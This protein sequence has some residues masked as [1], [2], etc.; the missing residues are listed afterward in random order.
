MSTRKFVAII[1]LGKPWC[2]LAYCIMTA[3]L[4]WGLGNSGF[5]Y[6]LAGHRWCRKLSANDRGMNCWI[7]SAGFMPFLIVITF[8]IL[9]PKRHFLKTFFSTAL[10]TTS[11]V[12]YFGA[13]HQIIYHYIEKCCSLFWLFLI[14]FEFQNL[15]PIQAYLIILY[16]FTVSLIAVLLQLLAIYSLLRRY[17]SKKIYSILKISQWGDF[18]MID[19]TTF[20]K[21]LEQ[22]DENWYTLTKKHNMSDST[23]HRL[24][25]NKDISTKTI[26][27]LC[28][29][30]KCDTQDIL[31]YIPSDTDQKL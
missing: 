3:A 6:G 24:K 23:L 15:C 11:G 22:S 5:R 1:L 29:I 26:N 27:D 20:W 16:F 7:Y 21:T 31:R 18:C 25:H 4:A 17:S 8:H 9:L 28:R 19:Y 30:L 2:I 12:C 13:M 10:Y 14:L